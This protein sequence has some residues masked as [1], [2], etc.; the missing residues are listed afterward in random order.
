M[1]RSSTCSTTD[2]TS[3][4]ERES[5]I[6]GRVVLG[7]AESRRTGWEGL[8][9]VDWIEPN[10]ESG[11]RQRSRFIVGAAYW[12]P[13]QGTVTTALLFDFENV[14]NNDFTPARADERRYAVHALISF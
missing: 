1:P 4:N 10:K 6:E 2:Q 13:H 3:T 7:G 9:R 8:F 12:F 5:E 11:C 14:D